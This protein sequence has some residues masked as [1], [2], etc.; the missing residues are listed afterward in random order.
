MTAMSDSTVTLS[1]MNIANA[2]AQLSGGALYFEGSVAVLTDV[3]AT[4]VTAIP[5]TSAA[6]ASVV[7]GGGFLYAGASV[8]TALGLDVSHARAAYGGAILIS[9]QNVAATPARLSHLT[10]THADASVA[11]GAI[12][13]DSGAALELSMTSIRHASSTKQG[14]AA[15]VVGAKLTLQGSVHVANSVSASG[16][17]GALFCSGAGSEL[18]VVDDDTGHLLVQGAVAQQRS[19]GGAA[20]IDNCDVE[21]RKTV[22]EDCSAAGNGGALLVSRAATVSAANAT[23]HRCVSMAYGGAVAVEGIDSHESIVVADGAADGCPSG[24]FKNTGAV[25]SFEEANFTANSAAVAGGA[26]SVRLPQATGNLWG[27]SVVRN[28]ATKDGGGL[29]VTGGGSSQ[30]GLGVAFVGNSAE[31][32]GAVSISGASQLDVGNA[33]FVDNVA[34]PDLGPAIF[35]TATAQVHLGAATSIDAGSS[36]VAIG[37]HGKECVCICVCVCVHAPSTWYCSHNHVAV[38]GLTFWL[39]RAAVM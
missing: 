15:C 8:V 34:L 20:V 27:G 24:S 10:I 31:A 26:M 22:F 18:V 5:S 35:G 23:F 13:V 29:F 37:Q 11:C 14:G 12:R 25:A 16:C 28:V 36:V 19:G 38:W 33:S 3:T 7:V 4:N 32:G 30:V 9:R 39:Y 6:S 1:A 17:G 21:L 2:T